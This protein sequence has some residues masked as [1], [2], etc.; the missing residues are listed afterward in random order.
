MLFITQIFIAVGNA[1]AN[2]I[3]DKELA[4]NTDKDNK[5]FER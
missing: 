3:F 5:L 4:D 1:I 2:P